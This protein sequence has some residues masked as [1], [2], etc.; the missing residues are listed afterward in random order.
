MA[1][2]FTKNTLTIDG[3]SLNWSVDEGRY[4]NVPVTRT[5]SAGD[6][7]DI[8]GFTYFFSVK[9]KKGD[10]DDNA[11]MIKTITS[12]TDPTNGVTQ[13]TLVDADTRDK[14]SGTYFYDYIECNASDQKNTIF[15]GSF[16]IIQAIG[17]STCS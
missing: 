17:D 16:K 2:S 7:I 3:K 9:N 12:H 11:L 6:P 10:S 8:T 4:L 1:T 14:Q 13:I 15:S 5:D